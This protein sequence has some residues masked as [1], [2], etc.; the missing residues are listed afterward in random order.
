MKIFLQ[1]SSIVRNMSFDTQLLPS[2]EITHLRAGSS[3]LTG[4]S[5]F[6]GLTLL[7]KPKDEV[8]E[9]SLITIDQVFND[10]V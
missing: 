8:S 5:S 1:M 3:T 9:T 2:V 7:K 4:A 6:A 10:Q